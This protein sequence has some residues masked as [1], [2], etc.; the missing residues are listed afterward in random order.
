MILNDIYTRVAEDIMAIPVLRGKKTPSQRFPGAVETYCIEGLMQDRKALQMGTSH[1]LGQNFAKPFNIRFQDKDGS[2]KYVYQTSWGVSTRLIGALI[3]AHSDDSGLVLPPP[4]APVQV[5]IVPIYKS[6][7]ERTGILSVARRIANSLADEEIRVEIDER[8]EYKPGFKFYDWELRGVPIRIELGPREVE[9]N[10]V[11]LSRRDTGEKQTASSES[12]PHTIC[13]LLAAIQKNL[14]ER[15]LKFQ[16]DNT[17]VTD[18]YGDFKKFM[19]GNGGFAYSPW[20]ERP[21][22]EEKVQEDTKATIRMIP[23]DAQV[24]EGKCIVC[25]APSKIRVPFAK[26]Y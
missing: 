13:D 23:L 20:C 19:D 8:E 21:E 18:D 22:C 7:S 14:Y 1:D 9:G 17:I 6:D 26:A 10:Q 16:R 24:K 4:L 25:G 3:M 15:A 5:I 12:L 2:L 11:V